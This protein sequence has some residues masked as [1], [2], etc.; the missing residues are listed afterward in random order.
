MALR[1]GPVMPWHSGQSLKR[2]RS[3]GLGHTG[4]S[5]HPGRARTGTAKS[6]GHHM[7]LVLWSGSYLI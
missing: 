4:T 7:G 5:L 2:K 6:S 1:K 3:G